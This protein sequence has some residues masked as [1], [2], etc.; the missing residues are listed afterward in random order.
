MAVVVQS[1]RGLLGDL[2]NHTHWGTA[3]V[4]LP[5]ANVMFEVL[6]NKA[7]LQMGFVVPL[8]VI[9]PYFASHCHR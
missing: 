4:M 7:H 6:A 5:P 3:V 2:S 8:L 9:T 1:H